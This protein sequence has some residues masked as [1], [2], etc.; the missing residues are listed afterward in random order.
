[1]CVPCLFDPL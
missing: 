1:M